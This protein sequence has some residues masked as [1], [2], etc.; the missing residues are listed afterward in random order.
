MQMNKVFKQAISKVIKFK[1]NNNNYNFHPNLNNK[2][3][4]VYK[5]NNNNYIKID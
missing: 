3:I 5:N 1:I 2:E 4:Q